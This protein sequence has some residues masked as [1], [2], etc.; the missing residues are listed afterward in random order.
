MTGPFF[1]PKPEYCNLFRA[2]MKY[3]ELTFPTAEANLACDE[4]L[5]DW[6]EAGAADEI[7]RCWEAS[8]PFVVLGHANQIVREADVQVCRDMGVPLLRR[9]T[10]GGAVVQGPGCLNYALILRIAQAAPLGSIP[11][12]NRWVMERHC[13]LFRD[14]LNADVRVRGHTDLAIGERKF[15][16]NSQ[17]R[18]RQ[19]LLFHGTF[20]L[21]FDL[22]LMTRLL[23]M[24]SKEPVYR[25]TRP[26]SDFLCNIG[27]PT[28]VVKSALRHAWQAPEELT[29]WPIRNVERLVAEKYSRREWNERF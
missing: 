28:E 27:V 25:A 29:D 21:T 5:L 20:L 14:I 3:L 2:Q 11:G 26:H 12:T 1:R 15:S 6:C 9:C 10:G 19:W 4:A 24:P 13:Q 16:G 7:L 22:P 17:R 8:S 23:P 18:R